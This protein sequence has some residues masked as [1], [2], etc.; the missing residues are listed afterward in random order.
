MRQVI[1]DTETTGLNPNDG[2]RV[3]EIGCIE[4]IDRRITESTFHVY[5]NPD[6]LVDEKAI[7]VHGI[8]NEFL[9]DKPNFADIA[10]EFIDFIRGSELIAHN[11]PFDVEFLNAELKRIPNAPM[12]SDLILGGEAFDTY[13]FARLKRPGKRNSL[14]ALCR[15][16]RIDS[17]ERSLHGALLDAELLTK[18]YLAMTREQSKIFANDSENATN[19]LFESV[20]KLKAL[21]RSPRKITPTQDETANHQAFIQH[22]RRE[23]KPLWDEQ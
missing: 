14:D 9:L 5:V 7:Q 3:I 20:Q 4:L 2:H 11:A 8:T 21:K 1:L 18:V 15:D 17:T 22:M 6:R 12:L 13:Q 10:D 19:S 16:Y 23:A